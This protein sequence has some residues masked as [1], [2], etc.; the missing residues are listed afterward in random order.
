MLPSDGLT[1]FLIGVVISM[2]GVST[3][4]VWT[5]QNAPDLGT[6][7]ISSG[8][9]MFTAL[10]VMAI[11]MGLELFMADFG[12][13]SKF[14][15]APPSFG[16]LM[17]PLLALNVYFSC[18]TQL[19]RDL[20]LKLPVRALVG[21]HAFRL[22]PEIF[23]HVGFMEGAL[24]AQMSWPPHGQNV[25][26]LVA[27]AALFLVIRHELHPPGLKWRHLRELPSGA[28]ERLNRKLVEL[29]RQR[30]EAQVRQARLSKREAEF[31]FTFKETIEVEFTAAEW[32]QFG[33][34]DLRISHFIRVPT[35]N[36]AKWRPV[37]GLPKGGRE[38]RSPKLVEKLQNQCYNKTGK[39]KEE[40][41]KHE[42]MGQ[43][44]S[45]FFKDLED[46]DRKKLQK[47]L[48]L[49]GV[50]GLDWRY[51]GSDKPRKGY[52]LFQN[53]ELARSLAALQHKTG[54][55]PTEGDLIYVGVEGIQRLSLEERLDQDHTGETT[56][57]QK[58]DFIKSSTGY[59]EPVFKP[60]A[61]PLVECT[62]S[63][64]A[65]FGITDLQ[66]GDFIKV[67]I[68]RDS[69]LAGLS[70]Y[71]VQDAK[72]ASTEEHI[73]FQPAVEDFYFQPAVDGLSLD[74]PRVVWWFAIFGFA[75][76]LN[77]LFIA[78]V[79]LS[80]PWRNWLMPHYEGGLEAVASVPYV[81]L[82]GFLFLLALCG[83]LLLFRR[84]MAR[85]RASPVQLL[86]GDFM[87]FISS[88]CGDLWASNP[89]CLAKISDDY[90]H[91]K[92]QDQ[93]QDQ[94][95]EEIV[96]KS[97]IGTAREIA[98]PVSSP[99]KS[100]D[101]SIRD[102]PTPSPDQLLQLKG[103]STPSPKKKVSLVPASSSPLSSEAVEKARAAR[104]PKF[105]S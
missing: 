64:W 40:F 70:P 1:M 61:T 91:L 38:R 78:M 48:Q 46:E 59:F 100:G 12:L 4:C 54:S 75:S 84:L 53:P 57:V 89:S 87:S 13:L 44:L 50:F 45:S 74:K 24:P 43:H 103:P 11:V 6:E 33:I 97:Y 98:S 65:Q 102:S 95:D 32:A 37:K 56:E 7:A 15:Q 99:E 86:C 80:H 69:V 101:V 88:K 21:F 94:A 17:V 49:G 63:E 20:A 76:V 10:Y 52:E 14:D 18:F 77:I 35:L 105:A 31:S 83:Q 73:Y 93:D 82:P 104:K 92:D 58:G 81:L 55:T 26:V 47:K 2:L 42:S 72:E 67:P 68:S 51:L 3:A 23:L 19:G 71:F 28:K 79:S 39:W 41:E 8:L 60:F 30:T 9:S 34:T 90:S 27:V 85:G 62:G 16:L 96:R 66:F 5:V 29:L 22:G 36:S 25:D